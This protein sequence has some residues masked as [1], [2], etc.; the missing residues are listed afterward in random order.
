MYKIFYKHL[1]ARCHIKWSCWQT[2]LLKVMLLDAIHTF[3]QLIVLLNQER[4]QDIYSI[5]IVYNI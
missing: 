4:N 3:Y 5:E 2:E 1:V